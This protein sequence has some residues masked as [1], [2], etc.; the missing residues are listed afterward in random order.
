MNNMK[1]Y[2]REVRVELS[3]RHLLRTI[4]IVANPV[5]GSDIR[6]IV[7]M[8]TAFDN[9]EKL[10]IVKR[11]ILG[12]DA[13]GVDKI[14]I[15]PDTFR[16]GSK[17]MEWVKRLSPIK[18]ECEVLDMEVTGT[19]LDTIRFSKKME[20][21]P[22]DCL[23]VLGGD[24]TSRAAAKSIKNTPLL[25]IS[26]GTNNVYPYFIE[27][28]VGGMAASVICNLAN[29]D[30]ICVQDKII[31][32]RVNNKISDIALVDAVITSDKHTGSK[33]IWD[34]EKI[35][36]IVVTRAH[37]EW[38][39]FSS[40][41]GSWEIIRPDDDFGAEIDLGGSENGVIASIAAG[42]IKGISIRKFRRLLLGE[43]CEYSASERCM[44]ALDGEREIMLNSGDHVSFIVK[45]SGP[46]RV[47]ISKT[48]EKA[49]R[50][51]LF[52]RK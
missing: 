21:I 15:M 52:M 8:A 25:P 18:A 39:G 27:G 2:I 38:I 37:P 30:D 35:K 24:G 12:A 5:S 44:I 42:I 4:G 7:S 46:V 20:E 33:A 36:K 43:I 22:A 51:G 28:T 48:L 50:L 29:H 11:I 19:I 41:V 6:R 9:N 32:I 31:E 10:N 13:I 23:I 1:I 34:I 14:Y 16:I 45:R 47:E 40:I 3:T 49:Q 26:T 17:V